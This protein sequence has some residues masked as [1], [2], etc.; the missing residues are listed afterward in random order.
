[1]SNYPTLFENIRIKIK[2]NLL[3]SNINK[4]YNFNQNYPNIFG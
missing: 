2:N 4:Q 1:M 3:F